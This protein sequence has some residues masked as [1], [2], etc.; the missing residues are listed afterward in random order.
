[1]SLEIIRASFTRPAD[2]TIYAA[3]D[4]LANSVTPG[5]VVPIA[6]TSSNVPCRIQRVTMLSSNDAVANKNFT[7]YLFTAQPTVTNGDNGAFALATQFSALQAVFGST[8]AVNT[9]AGAVN[10][11]YPLDGAATPQNGWIPQLMPGTFWGL[12]KV[13]A[14]YTPTSGET[15]TLLVEAW[16][17]AGDS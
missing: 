12:L 10:V 15:F 1:M 7:L 8:A 2:T 14:A 16:A 3:G 11:F 4:L 9:G 13:N 5:S 17:S 6:F